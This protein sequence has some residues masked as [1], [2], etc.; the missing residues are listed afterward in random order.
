MIKG[1]WPNA[2]LVGDNS[3]T[4]EPTFAI[5][6]EMWDEL[7]MNYRETLTAASNLCSGVKSVLDR[8]EIGRM[9]GEHALS[10]IKALWHVA[11][12]DVLDDQSFLMDVAGLSGASRDG[13]DPNLPS[14]EPTPRR[15]VH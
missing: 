10:H 11:H 9:D 1:P 5:S 6:K 7:V 3:P 12:C 15:R 8:V 2:G 14:E 4:G 13:D